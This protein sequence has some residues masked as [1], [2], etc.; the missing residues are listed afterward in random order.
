LYNLLLAI[1][2]A[3]VKAAVEDSLTAVLQAKL[4]RLAMKALIHGPG[5]PPAPQAALCGAE[6]THAGGEGGG[7]GGAQTG[8]GGGGGGGGGCEA[9]M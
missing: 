4:T 3:R 8:G 5:A 7:G 1:F 6:R 9:A 2:A